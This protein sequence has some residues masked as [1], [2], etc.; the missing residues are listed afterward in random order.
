MTK[1]TKLVGVIVAE[2]IVKN[3]RNW[4]LVSSRI[5]SLEK[6]IAEENLVFIQVYALTEDS[7]VLDKETFYSE[8]K[9]A[10]DKLEGRI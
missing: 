10:V 4:E 3:L 7:N 1:R 9:R 2:D 6:N 8:L 5:M